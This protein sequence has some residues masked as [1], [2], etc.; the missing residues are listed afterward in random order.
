MRKN[1]IEKLGDDLL[2]TPGKFK[3]NRVEL[4]SR[5]FDIE[6]K[7]SDILGIVNEVNIFENIFSNVVTGNV[8]LTETVDLPSNFPIVGHETIY[9]DI[10]NPE[11]DLVTENSVF[12]S[13]FKIYN[14]ASQTRPTDDTNVYVMN[15]QSEEIFKNH[16]TSISKA[17][18]GSSISDYV[19]SIYDE[20]LNM[21]KDIEIEPTREYYNF[22]IPNW[23]PFYSIAWLAQNAV[24]ETRF[25]SNY[26][27]FETR[28]G[29]VFSSLEKYFDGDVKQTYQYEKSNEGGT[30]PVEDSHTKITDYSIVRRF[31]I[32]DNIPIG[33]YSSKIIV[34]DII[35]REIIVNDYDYNDSYN[36]NSHLDDD[37][38]SFE[39]VMDDQVFEPQGDNSLID[40]E[41][42]GYSKSPL[43]FQKII[44]KHT[45]LYNEGSVSGG[46]RFISNDYTEST[47]Q[48]RI[49]QMAQL[50]NFMIS[51]VV[52]G[53]FE[54]KVGDIIYFEIPN[55]L[56]ID[57]LYSG[58]YIILTL[59]HTLNPENHNMEIIAA[60]DSYFSPLPA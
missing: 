56:G 46:V 39:W 53:D 16:M 44:S 24:S 3:L 57:R 27:F 54:R 55:R 36:K 30:S 19:K 49:S 37:E 5:L 28:D 31:N 10:S 2:I 12:E 8:M 48:S 14:L 17:Y 35:K 59:K 20:Y 29:F 52:P 40:P 1:L 41:V 26:M 43:S 9:F 50:N 23:K 45:G 13:E 6:N 51:F 11:I 7:R 18:T 58:R 32:L 15:F 42:D 21:G 33:M 22:V 25:G 34:H 4:S 47:I 60:K 38:A